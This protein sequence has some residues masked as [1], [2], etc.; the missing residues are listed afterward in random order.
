MPKAPSFAG[1]MMALRVG[2]VFLLL[3]PQAGAARAEA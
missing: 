1:R 3:G 2:S